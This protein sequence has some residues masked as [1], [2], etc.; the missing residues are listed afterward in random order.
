MT[1]AFQPSHELIGTD[2]NHRPH[3]AFLSSN[4]TSL[5]RA[6]HN[7]LK[8]RAASDVQLFR[9]FLFR[10]CCIELSQNHRMPWVGR[11]LEAH[12]PQPSQPWAP[13]GMGHPQLSGLKAGST[14]ARLRVALA[15]PQ[16]ALLAGCGSGGSWWFPTVRKQT[17]QSLCLKLFPSVTPVRQPCGS[18]TCLP[19]Y[20]YSCNTTEEQQSPQTGTQPQ[21]EHI[22]VL[23]LSGSLTHRAAARPSCPALVASPDTVAAEWG[24]RLWAAGSGSAS[25]RIHSAV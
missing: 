14:A 22:P 23:R 25:R 4:Q 9:K 20:T 10:F 11:D 3:L 7:T 12:Q 6:L 19:V 16:E 8:L 15:A 17:R 13:P 1:L 24:G 5:Q 21:P 2:T 18:P